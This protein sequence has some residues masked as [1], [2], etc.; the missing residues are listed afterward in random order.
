MEGLLV[1]AVF[2]ALDANLDISEGSM[3]IFTANTWRFSVT[4]HW[5]RA[6]NPPGLGRR[7][8]QPTATQVVN[9][10]PVGAL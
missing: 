5:V 8:W 3:N 6:S 10:I 4:L 1:G 7:T 9:P 2:P